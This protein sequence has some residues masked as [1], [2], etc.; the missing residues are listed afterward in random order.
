MEME[1]EVKGKVEIEFQNMFLNKVNRFVAVERHV[2]SRPLPS[3][4]KPRKL[5]VYEL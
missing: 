3:Y 4:L 1:M 2:G 5:I